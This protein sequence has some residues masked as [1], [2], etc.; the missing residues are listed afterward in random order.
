MASEAG[1]ELK[2]QVWTNFLRGATNEKTAYV[3]KNSV[4]YYMKMMEISK[5]EELLEGTNE[6]QEARLLDYVAKEKERHTSSSL[7]RHRLCALK[8]F[9]D[10]N[11][12]PLNWKFVRKT[13]G[14]TKKHKDRAYTHDEIR[15]ALKVADP[16]TKTLIILLA[17]TGMREGAVPTLDIGNMHLI[18]KYGIYKFVVYEGYDEQYV[19]FCTPEAKQAIDDYL[20]YRRRFGEKLSET[21][22]LFRQ[23]FRS[24]DP[25][26]VQ[27]ARRISEGSIDDTITKAM[28]KAGVRKRVHLTEGVISGKI[29]HPVKA[30]HGLRKFYDTQTT[31]SGI[32]PLWVEVL[33]GHDIKLKESYFRPSETDLLEGN[34]KMV[35]YV[36]AINALTINEEHKLRI[37]VSS[38][39]EE[40]RN[41]P[42]RAVV[43]N[44]ADTVKALSKTVQDLQTAALKGTLKDPGE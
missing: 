30:V 39:T 23:D 9:Y 3:Y 13:I 21:S 15:R 28:E 8:L 10:M 35:G 33:E 43:D 29:R 20:E 11:R 31:I 4:L 40:L 18:E 25:D 14:K 27:L 38:L 34:D 17:S 24:D 16:R 5:A 22:P 41:A 7:I 2:G 19:T 1:I 12:R 32:T 37:Q 6:L 44:L 42:S 36:G 26:R